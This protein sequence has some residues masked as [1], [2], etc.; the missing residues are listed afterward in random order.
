LFGCVEPLAELLSPGG[1]PGCLADEAEPVQAP[2]RRHFAFKGEQDVYRRGDRFL[3][4]AL[5]QE[6]VG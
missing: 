6:R 3:A 5:H 1:V 2:D 4:G